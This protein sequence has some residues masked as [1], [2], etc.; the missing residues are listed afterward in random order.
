ML[1]VYT[2]SGAETRPVP[3]GADG[4]AAEIGRNAV[5]VD[6]FDPSDAERAAVEKALG[7]ALPSYEDIHEIEASSRLYEENGILFATATVISKA[8]APKPET[9]ALTFIIAGDRLVTLRYIDPL[10]VKT[11]AAHLARHPAAATSAEAVTAGLLDAII[12]RI[13]D[14]L[15]MV[16]AEIDGVSG[17]IFDPDTRRRPRRTG[18]DFRRF[19]T[20]IG[21]GGDLTSKARESLV[22]IDRLLTFLAQSLEQSA[23]KEIRN[24][25][26]T[27]GRDIQSLSDHA[28]FL[29]NKVGFL[30]DATLGVLSIEQNNIIK[31]F[32]VAAVAFLPPTLIAS[33]YGM[34]FEHMPELDWPWGYPL[35]LVA[36]IV[37]AILPLLYFRRRGWL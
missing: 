28:A 29:A 32:S 19:M 15:E 14:I 6:L 20:R 13:A 5:W 1:T 36:M 30:L 37:S 26:K 18:D 27:L 33:I 31:I 4:S 24:R 21:R 35:A 11:Y 2:P 8:D 34:N 7:I 25:R 12:D 3:A 16:S 10:P 17:E 23:S 9:G 22:T